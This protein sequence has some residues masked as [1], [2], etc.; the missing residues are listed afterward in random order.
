MNEKRI[1]VSENL[2]KLA[3]KLKSRA[4][5]FLV[6]GY[7]RNAIMGFC[8]TDVDLASEISPDEL[9]QMLK[10]SDFKVIDKSKKLGTVLIKIGD[11]EYEHT[12]FRKETYDDSGKHQP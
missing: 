3:L 1:V 6:G 2:E 11:E 5:I 9:K 7:V 12:T 10:Y 4:D 8:E